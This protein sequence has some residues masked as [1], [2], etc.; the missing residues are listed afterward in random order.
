MATSDSIPAMDH[1]YHMLHA[2]YSNDPVEEN[3][4]LTKLGYEKDHEL[5]QKKDLVYV[6]RDTKKAYV[7]HRGTNPMDPADLATDAALGLGIQNYTPRF[8]KAKR[9][10]KKVQGKY[11]KENTTALGHSLGGAVASESGALT[12]ITYNRGVGLGHVGR[13]TKK[14][15]VDYRTSG[16]AVSALSKFTRYE[17]GSEKHIV[18]SRQRKHKESIASYALDSH[19]LEWLK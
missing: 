15:Q 6:H 19:H 4:R 2:G 13:K 18:H 5:S 1:M 11:G 10:T 12:R 17:K 7:V 3:H 14:G 16:D 9:L 8:R